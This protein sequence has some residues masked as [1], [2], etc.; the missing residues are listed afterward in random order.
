VAEQILFYLFAV[1]AIISALSAVTRKNPVVSAVWL[2]SCMCSLAV[3][4]VLLEAYFLAAVQVI[5][6]AGAVLMLFVFVIMLLNLRTGIIGQFRN[7]GLKF[8]GLVL[9]VI[10]LRQFYTAFKGTSLILGNAGGLEP[11][12]GEARAVGELLF[13]RYVYPL[14]LISILLLVAI[15]GA[16]VL[17]GK[18]SS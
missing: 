7:L 8:M 17:A 14:E 18:E 10:I 2:V 6:Y 5:V 12:F 13:T 3:I 16:L 4:Y 1:I 9:T 15:V 11:G